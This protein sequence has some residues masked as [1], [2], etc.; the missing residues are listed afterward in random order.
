[1][2]TQNYKVSDFHLLFLKIEFLSICQIQYHYKTNASKLSDNT[3]EK[4]TPFL[5]AFTFK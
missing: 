5:S 1:M 3:F 4:L 2:K